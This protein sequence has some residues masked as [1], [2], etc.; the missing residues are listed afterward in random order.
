MNIIRNY[1]AMLWSWLTFNLQ[2]VMFNV[3]QAELVYIHIY[4]LRS[5]LLSFCFLIVLYLYHLTTSI[6]LCIL[7]LLDLY[8]D[9]EIFSFIIYHLTKQIRT[10]NFRIWSNI[11]ENFSSYA[12]WIVPIFIYFKTR[13]ALCKIKT[14]ILQAP[15]LLS[16]L[17]SYCFTFKQMLFISPQKFHWIY[18]EF[19]MIAPS[20][21]SLKSWDIFSSPRLLISLRKRLHIHNGSNRKSPLRNNSAF[22]ISRKNTLLVY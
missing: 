1:T 5:L 4:H 13:E 6:G 11:S 14:K 21:K 18:P 15:S 20:S 3:I 16:Y 2:N 19:C 8:S 10:V 12:V 22:Y 7:H 17:Q 9:F